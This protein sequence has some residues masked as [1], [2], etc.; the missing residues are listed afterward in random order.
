[1]KVTEKGPAGSPSAGE[2][3]FLVIGKIRRPHGVMGDLLVETQSGFPDQMLPGMQIYIGDDHFPVKITRN[4]NHKDG[5][6]LGFEGFNTPEQV[7][8]FRNQWVYSTGVKRKRLSKG[9]YFH[10]ELIG[11]DVVDDQG[12]FLGKITQ[13]LETGANDVYVV[14]NTSANEILLPA[15]PDVISKI[16]LK[17]KKMI[18]HLLPGLI[19]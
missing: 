5:V 8:K 19:G 7:G 10:R 3:V 9:E 12:R 4:R 15:I 13:I 11:L 6:L 2:P 18:V 17:S 16:D 1:M 14:E